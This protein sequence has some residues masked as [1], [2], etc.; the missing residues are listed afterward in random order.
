MQFATLFPVHNPCKRAHL[1][2]EIC[3]TQ[4]E[5]NFG[6]TMFLHYLRPE[7]CQNPTQKDTNFRNAMFL[8]Y[9][10]PEKC[11]NPT[12]KDTNFG[13]AIILCYLEPG[14]CQIQL[15]KTRILHKTALID[16]SKN[17]KEVFSFPEFRTS[18]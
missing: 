13:N 11:Q 4:K 2:N 14:N 6:N 5:T 18:F 16:P 17:A 1:Q 3:P 12:Q 10:R 15:R 8:C 9:L 7:K